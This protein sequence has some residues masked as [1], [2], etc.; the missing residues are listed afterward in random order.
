M[1]LLKAIILWIALFYLSFANINVEKLQTQFIKDVLILSAYKDRYNNYLESQCQ[2]DIQCT[3]N[4]IETLKEWDSVRNDTK[5]QEL[6]QSRLSLA[7]IEQNYLKKIKTKL[8]NL[9]LDL[10]SSQFLTIID[11]EQQKLILLLWDKELEQFH[12]IG[13]NFVSTGNMEREIE[14]KLGE[15]HYL[16][17]P[18][19]IF[20]A[21]KGWRSDG[22]A[23][24][25]NNKILG[26]GK[27][28]RYIFYFGE[29]I[30]IRYNVFDQERNKIYKKEDWQLIRDTLKFAMHS[31][32]SPMKMGTPNS[33][34]C[35]RM[36]DELNRF[37]DN[38]FVLHKPNII[39]DQWEH[40]YAKPP[41]NP[42]N[43]NLAGQYLIIFDQI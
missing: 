39:N 15:D 25:D 16:K 1:I 18:A 29:H 14:I 36:N 10:E 2:D 33:H 38:H 6:L 35:I 34:G 12:F 31:H 37:L 30:T 28:D 27:K 41:K 32:E 4:T 19:G 8:F 11:L 42:Q 24:K 43:M 5:L 9:Q 13:Q 22:K 40:K 23:H 26:Y 3:C 20:K 7:F 17:T 21:H